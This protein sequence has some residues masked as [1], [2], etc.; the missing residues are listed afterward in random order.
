MT[1]PEISGELSPVELPKSPMSKADKERAY[2]DM[3]LMLSPS[4][5]IEA[6]TYEEAQDID[7]LVGSKGNLGQAVLSE[8]AVNCRYNREVYEDD[9]ED[10]IYESKAILELIEV[11]RNGTHQDAEIMRLFRSA[12]ARLYFEQANQKKNRTIENG[13]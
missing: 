13:I 9:V 5:L 11:V 2:E 3:T 4:D 6:M 7:R 12:R 1:H 10:F 8:S